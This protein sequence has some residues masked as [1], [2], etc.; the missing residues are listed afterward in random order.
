KTQS[1][2][3]ALVQSHLECI[4]VGVAS[5]CRFRNKGEP[6]KLFGV[7]PRCRNSRSAGL[8][9]GYAGGR[10]AGTCQTGADYRWG[11]SRTHR[12]PVDILIG[13]FVVTVVSH[14]GHVE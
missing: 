8:T 5:K 6:W 13:R 3:G 4:V 11:I 2:P 1:V 7:G 14:I 10:A 9:S 12:N